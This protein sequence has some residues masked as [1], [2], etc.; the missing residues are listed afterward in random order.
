MIRSKAL[1]LLTGLAGCAALAF[2]VRAALAQS[3]PPDRGKEVI[4]RST[5]AVVGKT[6]TPP[7]A[8]ADFVNPK[9]PPGKVQW[10]AGFADACKAAAKSGKPVLLF[11]M[12]G[13]LDDQFC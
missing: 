8:G 1:L 4:E 10:H 11:Q 6:A 7:V 3:R 2:A 5:K 12:M 13:K 9:V